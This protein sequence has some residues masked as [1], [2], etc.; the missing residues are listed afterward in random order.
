MPPHVVAKAVC[1]GYE[2]IS[3]E[4]LHGK[5]DLQEIIAEQVVPGLAAYFGVDEGEM[6]LTRNATEALHLQAMGLIL[7]PGDEV[8]VTSQEHPAGNSPW[9]LRAERH[10]IR[11]SE[12][13]IPSPFD[14][15]EQVVDLMESAITPRT[16]ALSF[17]HVTRGGHLYPVKEISEMAH[18]HGLLSLVDGA[19]AVGQFSVDLHD[20]ACDAYS[21]SLHKWVLGPAGTGFMYVREVA[22]DVIRTNFSAGA[23]VESPG[24][25]PGGTADFPVRAALATAL[26]FC[27]ALGANQV[28]RRC[29]Y[30]SNHLKSGLTQIDGVT[31]LSGPTPET[32]CPGSTIFEKEGLDA[33]RAVGLFEERIGTHIDEHQRDGHNAIRVSTHVYNTTAEIDRFLEELSTARA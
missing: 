27:N 2:A 22:R 10:G 32:S 24:L 11:V 16:R 7:K 9:M 4:P 21:A 29:R 19:Q 15:G 33:V 5:H 1:D 30:L 26:D 23:T 12:V 25:A 6:S 17:C 13:F 8:L 28:E 31:I 3:R 18:R 14:S 20:L